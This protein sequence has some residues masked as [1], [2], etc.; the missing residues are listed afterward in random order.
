MFRRSG[1]LTTAVLLLLAGPAHAHRLEAEAVVR[2]F[3]LVQVESW[4]ET[5][6]LPRSARVEVFGPDGQ[7]L[8]EGRTDNQGAFVFPYGGAGPLRVEVNAGAGHLA[9][10]RVTAEQLRQGA[11]QTRAVRTWIACVTPAPTPFAIAPLLVEVRSIPPT[12]P[13]PP[14]EV[15]IQFG[16]LALGVIILLGVAAGAMGL[17]KLR[18]RREEAVGR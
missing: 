17:R 5:G 18:Q 15:G 14:P 11:E 1:P 9:K 4:Y 8:L 6:D 2:P 7:R 3:G 10:V 12:T 13:P 16:K